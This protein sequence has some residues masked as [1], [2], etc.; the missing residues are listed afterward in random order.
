MPRNPAQDR[1]AIVGVGSTGFSRHDPRSRDGLGLQA[2]VRAVRDAGLGPD[3]IDGVCGTNP[4]APAIAAGLGLRHVRFF[5]NQVPPIAFSLMAAAAAIWAGQCETALVVHSVLRKGV[6]DDPLRARSDPGGSIPLALL[7]LPGPISVPD[8]RFVPDPESAVGSNAYAAWASRYLHEYAVEREDFGLVAVNAHTNAV[9]NPL[10]ASRGPISL[11]E[12]RASPPV[13]DPLRRADYELA[14]DGADAFVLTTVER[15]RDLPRSAV[16]IH[17][18]GAAINESRAD[19]QLPGLAE[20]GQHLVAGDVR[21]IS[22]LWV[23]D[24]DL[25]LLYDGTTFIVL[26]WLEALGWCRPGEAG[27]FLRSHW[28]AGRSRVALPGD[29]LLNPHG[30]SLAEGATQGSGQVR[31]AVL[32]L[33][34]EAGD[35]QVPGANSALLGI[36]GLFFNAQAM[37]LRADR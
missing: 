18:A 34:G 28:D 10:A 4:S 24:V 32:Q 37:V 36:G 12:Y 5:G 35:R 29:R 33:R 1:I 21:S 19:D 27:A 23:D 6:R 7:P 3:D 2:A 8:P 25:C 26:S 9:G 16:L 11:D 31:E 22:D 30:G 20:H 14:V 17:A 15:A 13:V